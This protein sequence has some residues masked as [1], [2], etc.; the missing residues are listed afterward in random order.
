[1]RVSERLKKAE[2]D[3]TLRFRRIGNPSRKWMGV[4]SRGYDSADFQADDWEILQSYGEI[5]HDVYWGDCPRFGSWNTLIEESKAEWE[6]IGSHAGMRLSK[7]EG[8]CSKRRDSDETRRS[9]RQ[10]TRGP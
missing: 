6:R 4:S 8:S 1:M 3:V 5:A 9:D 2:K 10:N 7:S